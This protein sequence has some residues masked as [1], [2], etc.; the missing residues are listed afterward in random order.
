MM[1]CSVTPGRMFAWMTMAWRRLVPPEALSS[2][3][4]LFVVR[5][6]QVPLDLAEIVRVVRTRRGH[7][8]RLRPVEIL[9]VV[10]HHVIG[11]DDFLRAQVVDAGCAA[12]GGC[13]DGGGDGTQAEAGCVIRRA[14]ARDFGGR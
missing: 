2:C 4:K 13:R 12:G 8:P 1:V 7:V 11:D 9:R 14:A 3:Q 10:P 6:G 5:P